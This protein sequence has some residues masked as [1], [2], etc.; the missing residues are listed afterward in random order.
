MFSSLKIRLWLLGIAFMINLQTGSNSLAYEEHAY[1]VLEILEAFELRNYS[2]AV[3]AEVAASGEF[4]D[5]GKIAFRVLFGFI[6][7]NNVPSQSLGMTT[8]VIQQLAEGVKISTTTPVLLQPSETG[9][10]E[11]LFSFVMPSKYTIETIPKA[12]DPIIVIKE[13]PERRVA[14]RI[15]SGLWTQKTYQSNENILLNSMVNRNIQPSSEFIV[16]RH[17]S[18]FNLWFLRRNEVLVELEG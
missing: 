6:S 1:T 10:G 17:N 11:Y 18:P 12:I 4:D 8:P 3:V 14:A 7:G 16:A 15:F 2:S 5:V 13:I 9:K